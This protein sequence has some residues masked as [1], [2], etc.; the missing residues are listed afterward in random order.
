MKR[1]QN[2]YFEDGVGLTTV[3]S[4]VL[5]LTVAAALVTAD[6]VT[7]MQM[8]IPVTLGALA[9]SL[10]TATSRFDSF[11]AFSHG[12][13]TGLAW[14]LYLMAGTVTPA[15]R[16]PFLLHGFSTLQANVYTVLLRLL[17]W[18]Q[19]IAAPQTTTDPYVRMFGLSF[20]LWWLTYLGIWSIF[21]H[22]YTWRAVIPAGLVLL[23]QSVYAQQSLVPYLVVFAFVALLLLARTNLAEQQ[24]RWRFQHAYVSKTIAPDVMRT[25]MSYVMLVLCSAWLLPGL[26][27][28]AVIRDVLPDPSAIWTTLHNEVEELLGLPTPR[29]SASTA[30][31]TEALSLGGERTAD[32]Q[33]IFTVYANEARYW[34]AVVF[35]IYNG[36]GWENTTELQMDFAAK[37]ALPVADWQLREPLT[38]T[39]VLHEST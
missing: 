33:I 2:L 29:N 14:I 32:D 38:Q 27:R 10:L 19:V 21:R 13:L 7:T 22:G 18:T 9:V 26:G 31:F 36:R 39:I 28:S 16:E 34:R 3:L 35:D 6:G 11:F 8:L 12:M 25:G 4:T 17:Q 20:L 24:L 37:S 5:F 1:V 23:I 15:E 30:R